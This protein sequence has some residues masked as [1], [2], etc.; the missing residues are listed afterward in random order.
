MTQPTYNNQKIWWCVQCGVWH[1]MNHGHVWNAY[2]HRKIYGRKEK[3]TRK[4]GERV[5][6][7]N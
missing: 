4:K 3:L 7:R 6:L 2:C 1:G 5:V